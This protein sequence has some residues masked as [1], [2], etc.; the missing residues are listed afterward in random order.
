MSNYYELEAYGEVFRVKAVKTSYLDSGSLAVFLITDEGEDFATLTVNLSSK[1]AYGNL[2]FVDTNNCDWAI[3]WL[4]KTEIARPISYWE[5][6]GFCKYP[7][8]EFNID[9]LEDL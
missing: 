6:S 3:D 4:E 9:M 8:Y 1:K 5:Q 7:L 2:A